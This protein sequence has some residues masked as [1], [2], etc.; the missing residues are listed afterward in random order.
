MIWCQ[1]PPGSSYSVLTSLSAAFLVD[2]L[3]DFLAEDFLVF[4]LRDAGIYCYYNIGKGRQSGLLDEK[5]LVPSGRGA[6]GD[7]LISIGILVFAVFIIFA[8]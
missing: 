2:F 7:T 8:G 6:D 1:K 3:V 5:W 4:F